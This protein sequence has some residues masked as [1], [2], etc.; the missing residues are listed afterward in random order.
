MTECNENSCNE[1]SECSNS[2][3]T[4]CEMTD[5]MMCLADEAWKQLMVEKMKQQFEQQR[6]EKMNRVAAASIEASIAKWEHKMSG[7]MKCQEAK[8][9]LKAAF[10][11]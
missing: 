4:G 8:G 9:K 7:K 5:M 3:G 6:G 11:G 10:M 2:K 1:Q